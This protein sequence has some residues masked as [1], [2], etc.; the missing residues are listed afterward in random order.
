[1]RVLCVWMCVVDERKL[2]CVCVRVFC[3]YKV[4]SVPLKLYYASG[5]R[6]SSIAGIGASSTATAGASTFSAATVALTTALSSSLAAQ[7]PL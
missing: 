3:F 1:M 4:Q 7:R 2:A 6:A 5:A